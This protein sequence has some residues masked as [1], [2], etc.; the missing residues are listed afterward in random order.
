MCGDSNIYSNMITSINSAKEYAKTIVN[1]CN[2]SS[3]DFN[4]V[5]NYCRENFNELETLTRW[6]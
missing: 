1:E 2:C 3:S 6:F 4:A 5:V